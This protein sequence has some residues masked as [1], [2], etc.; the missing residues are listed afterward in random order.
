M[1]KNGMIGAMTAVVALLLLMAFPSCVNEE[2]ELSKDRLNLEVT[3]FED[4]LS[5]PLGSTSQIM[6]KDLKDSLLT[7]LE[8][9]SYL[10]YFVVDKDGAY[11]LSV[12]DC[13]DLSDTLNNMLSDIEI[14]DVAISETFSF[15]LA[16]ADVSDLK[17]DASEYSYSEDLGGMITVPDLSIDGFGSDFTIETEIYKYKPSA[18]L[19]KLNFPALSHDAG[20]A[21]IETDFTI[22]DRFINDIPISLDMFATNPLLPA[23]NISTGFGPDNCHLSFSMSMPEG[24]SSVEDIVLHEG[25]K[26]IMSVELRN[27]FFTAGTIKPHLDLDIHELFHLTKEENEGHDPLTIDHILADFEIP[28]SGGKVTEEYDIQSLVFSDD[29]WSMEDGRLTLHKEIDVVVSGALA[30]SDVAT[31]TRHLAS[32]TEKSM[33]IHMSVEFVDFQVDDVRMAIDPVSIEVPE[34][35]VS[36]SQSISLPEQIRSIG[37]VALSQD[38]KITMSL[39]PENM[40]P[41]LEL[42]LESLK[43]TFPEGVE[44]E[45]ASNG[46]LEYKDVDLS[47]G[48]THSMR[49]IGLTL[50]EPQDGDIVLDKEV[51]VEAVL[52]AG[53]TV[54]SASLPSS[55]SDDLRMKVEVN[56]EMSIEDYSVNI[57]G[58]DYPVSYSQDFEVDV[59]GLEEFGTVIVKPQGEPVV[60]L[61]IVMPE[62]DIRIVADP[63]ENLVISFP[64]M[65]RFKDLPQEY[66]YDAEAG[67]ITIKGEIP[68]VMNLP[69]D[70][71]VITPVQDGDSYWARGEFKV[72]GGIA[73]PEGSITRKDVDA[74]TAP[75]SKVGVSIKIP[76]LVLGTLEMDKPYTKPV[77]KKFEV[78]MMSADDIPAE[79]V[80]I[81]RVELEDVY[82]NMQ[83]DASRLPDLGKT[84]L[85]LD[86][87]IDLPEM[88]VLESDNLK[89]GNVLTVKGEL[90]EEGMIV[91]DPIKIVALDLAGI[92]LKD[93]EDLKDTVS[94]NG[95]LMLDDVALDISEWLG[96]T[97][98]VKVDAGIRDI[99]ISK[100]VGKVDFQMDPISESIDLT[101]VKG[102]L[103]NGNIEVSGIENLL[104]R[105]S[106]AADIKTNV[107]VPMGAMMEI[108]PFSGGNPVQDAIWKT[109]VVLN[110]SQSASETTHTRYWISNLDEAED[111]FRPEGYTH[112]RIP[113]QQY[114]SDI[115]D[116]L[117]ISLSAGTDPQQQCVIEPNH[118]YVVEASYSAQIPMEFGD[119]ASVTYRDTIPDI[120]EIVGQLLQ[121][122]DLVLTGSVTSS[123]P[124][125]V[126]MKVNLMDSDGSMIPL[127]ET[128]SSQKIKGC[129]PDG[130]PVVTEINLGIQKQEGARVKDVSAIE[131]EFTVS[132]VAGVPLSDNCFIQAVLQALVPKGVSVDIDELMK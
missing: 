39:E 95:Q 21:D 76:E 3:V 131:V 34:E 99:V 84:R 22:D 64:Q 4:G 7:S 30:Y 19:L 43:M 25:A 9:T 115:P 89:E 54:S 130:E 90:D 33:D 57:Y 117:S 110:H 14:P 5:V 69:V 92:N 106:L 121:L 56:A 113:L 88:I 104:S 36:F 15:D 49:I 26:V 98:E 83:L 79:I 60:S 16:E 38:S 100:V 31:T 62:S 129:G 46:I 81:E 47:K 85:S 32:L 51:S 132:T 66:N 68:S 103:E 107:G 63:K 126:D 77:T 29:D 108:V 80:S 2:Y 87:D 118:E 42:E 44:V 114:L 86:F 48:F 75:D 12:S 93:L 94:I 20:F 27:S 23:M 40:L 116:S 72:S 124:L 67:T 53:G 119:G 8:D 58:Y 59:T 10:K 50:P 120:P 17:V 55:K 82:F 112:I 102:Y 35:T 127:D 28:A 97:L 1:K 65:I 78:E 18:D 71:L 122:G 52:K 37:H 125:E 70:C 128:T 96:K 24:I 74:L 101:E 123:L 91:V 13:L 41:G 73:I 6:L 105:L 109:E 61:E 111:K 45:G 11:G